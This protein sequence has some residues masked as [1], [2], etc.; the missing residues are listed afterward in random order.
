MK[1]KCRERGK[2]EEKKVNKRNTNGVVETR[3]TYSKN[4]QNNTKYCLLR[5]FETLV[6]WK[7]CIKM[8]T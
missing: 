5:R 6:K 7:K 4:P 2:Q 3:I 8:K 1:Q